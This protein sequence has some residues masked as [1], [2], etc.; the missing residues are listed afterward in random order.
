MTVRARLSR[1][2]EPPGLARLLWWGGWLPG[3]VGVSALLSD[4]LWRTRW[5]GSNPIKA[6]EHEL[7]QWVLRFLLATLAVTPVRRTLGWNWL[8]KHR[9]RLG[10]FAFGYAAAH[11]LTYALLDVQLDAAELSK[12]L[13]KRPYIIVGF[14]ALVALVP[15]AVT[16]TT[17]W[18]Q[19]LKQRW[20]TLHA[21]I[22]PVAVLGVVHYWMS[23][24]KDLT[25]PVTYAGLLAGLLAWRWSVRR[26]A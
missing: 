20:T 18:I 4:L 6:L 10:L 9:R 26:A 2:P 1:V 22:Y 16:S 11:F 24:K 23:V 3:V 19:R 8:A 21:L 5:L 25:G 7:G 15:L 17:A 12:D 14:V 13:T